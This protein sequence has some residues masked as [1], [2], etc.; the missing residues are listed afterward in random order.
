M[1]LEREEIDLPFNVRVYEGGF[2][3]LAP[4]TYVHDVYIWLHSEMD[5]V[6]NLTIR[7]NG[8]LEVYEHAFTEG[9]DENHAY[10]RTVRIQDDGTLKAETSAVHETLRDFHFD[11]DYLYVEGGG[12]FEGTSMFI[13]S[14]YIKTDNGGYIHA[15]GYGYCPDET[16]DTAYGINI[17]VGTW[18]SDGSSGGGHGGTSGRGGGLDAVAT[19]QPYGHLFEPTT[20]GE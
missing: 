1:D 19:G 15:N 7:R 20:L 4:V 13:V 10:F 14:D 8:S 6:V 5:H 17:G 3:G 11:I 9:S 16:Q 18:H 2:I 12:N